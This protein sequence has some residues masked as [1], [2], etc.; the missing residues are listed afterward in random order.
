VVLAVLMP[1]VASIGGNAGTQALAVAVRALAT[2]EVNASNVLRIVGREISVGLANGVA[3]GVLLAGVA[4]L[5]FQ[6]PQLSL[7]IGL[8]VL[9]NLCAAALAGVLMPLTL[10][11]LGRDPA[12]ASPVFVTWITDTVGFLSFLGLAALI[13][14]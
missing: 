11:R 1:V 8:A 6:N 2:R 9:I 5:W 7:V 3:I 13:L 4:Y 10:D 12:V 14:L